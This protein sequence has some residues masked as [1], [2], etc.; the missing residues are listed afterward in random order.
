MINN[1]QGQAAL[2]TRD[3]LRALAIFLKTST[4]IGND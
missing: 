4:E 3:D 2:L 1:L